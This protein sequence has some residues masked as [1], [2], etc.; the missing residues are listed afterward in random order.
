MKVIAY[1]TM[2][3]TI[4][5]EVDDKFARLEKVLKVINKKLPYEINKEENEFPD[6][7]ENDLIDEI[8]TQV[9]KSFHCTVLAADV[10]T[11][12]GKM[13]LANYEK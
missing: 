12:D 3:K 13:V 5:L 2:Q 1:C 6:K 11:S 8:I 9:N 7:L 10:W 4:E